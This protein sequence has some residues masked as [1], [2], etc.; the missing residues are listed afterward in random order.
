MNDD[1][2]NPA[3][4]GSGYIPD[5]N[6]P[7]QA[8]QP[9]KKARPSVAPKPTSSTSEFYTKDPKIMERSV[10]RAAM[11]QF[12][13]KLE[14]TLGGR[15]DTDK[16]TPG[17]ATKEPVASES[18]ESFNA[19]TGKVLQPRERLGA[20]DSKTMV[21]PRRPEEL[22][23]VSGR[24]NPITQSTKSEPLSEINRAVEKLIGESKND[25]LKQEVGNAIKLETEY[26]QLE[27][28]YK[29][30]KLEG[31][32]DKEMKREAIQKL[33]DAIKIYSSTFMHNDLI[34]GG[35]HP[36]RRA[37]ELT[38]ENREI[39][40]RILDRLGECYLEKAL[41]GPKEEAKK[42]YELARNN[43]EKAKEK[44]LGKVTDIGRE[45]REGEKA[46]AEG[47]D[48]VSQYNVG[49]KLFNMSKVEKDESKALGNKEEAV[50]WLRKASD[51]GSAVAK[52]QL[53]NIF[54]DTKPDQMP[55][56]QSLKVSAKYYQEAIDTYNKNS[57]NKGTGEA[58]RLL[59][60]RYES[61]IGVTKE[62]KKAVEL[63]GK[64]AVKGDKLA[65]KYLS[66]LASTGDVEA[67]K[68]LNALKAKNG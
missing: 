62:P 59:G 15:A 43:F 22:A 40:A 28:E 44:M 24:Q 45:V 54:V 30:K 10:D 36:D 8:G 49:M 42:N 65:E 51:N 57:I 11:A 66:E 2:T 4:G 32:P 21:R 67:Q 20:G 27:A 23:P 5:P 25:L 46:E 35:Q 41:N 64:A 26:K 29:K 60:D 31:S 7:G 38:S 12:K 68:A 19:V 3:S 50:K 14:A 9:T 55:S 1:V 56:E 58:E 39:K 48:Q 47:G 6:V 52:L 53:A 37:R 33:T 34:E 63:Y 17:H 16:L 18:D 13:A 61:G